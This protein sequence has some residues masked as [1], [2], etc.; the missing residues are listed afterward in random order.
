MQIKKFQG[1]YDS[2]FAYLIIEGK[3]CALIDPSVPSNEVLDYINE[4]NLQLKFVVVMHGHFDHTVEL[5]KYGCES[6]GH[7]LLKIKINN[8]IEDGDILS[9]SSL[10]FK[11]IYTPGHTQDAICILI[12]N[13]LFTSDTLFVE[14]CGRTDL[15]GGNTEQLWE[16]L[17]KLKQ[18]PDN[19]IIYPGHD[20]GSTKTS[21][22]G[23]EKENNRFFNK[24]KEEFLAIR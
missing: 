4:N 22:I 18:L 15:E 1:G 11:V 3:E 23:K 5:Q 21:T 14:G 10:R 24:T 13:N 12:E 9:L 16:S 8:N 20:Y 17:E 19:T 7:S 6:Y 2:N